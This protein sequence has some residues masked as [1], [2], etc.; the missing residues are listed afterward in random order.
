MSKFEKIG[1]MRLPCLLATGE[2]EHFKLYTYK[3]PKEKYYYV[4]ER[5]KVKDSKNPLVRIHSACSF[6]H[7]FSSQR[8][9]CH[10]QLNEAL[11]KIS[12]GREGLIIYAW[13]HEGRSVGMW[14]H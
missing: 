9:D 7:V 3:F 12:E 5:G 14:N 2:V 1:P 6:A 10:A 4:V 11:I 13:P 8:C